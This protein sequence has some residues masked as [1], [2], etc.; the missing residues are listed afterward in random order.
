MATRG[1]ARI[2]TVPCPHPKVAPT[3]QA[4]A[5]TSPASAL[6]ERDLELAEIG[7]G[8]LGAVRRDGR[9]LLVQG[10]AGIGK[11]VLLRAARE[12]AAAQG[13][14][15][16]GATG[17]E[18]DRDFPFGIVHQLL[19]GVVAEAG[20][21]RRAALFAGAA[22]HAE[23]VFGGTDPA[24]SGDPGHVVLHAL[25]WLCA[26]LADEAPVALV[27]DDLHWADRASLRF[28]EFL[29]RRLEG[30][31]LLVVAA[32]RVDEPGADHEL[33]RALGRGPAARVLEPGPLSGEAT[34]R[35]L[36]DA[37]GADPEPAFAGASQDATGGNPLL[38]RT[39]ARLAAERGLRGRGDEAGAVAE[40]GARGMAD[41]VRGRLDGLGEDAILAARALAL[42]GERAVLE[43]VAALAAR[44]PEEAAAA[45]DT[46]ARA[47]IVDPDGRDFVHPL[48]RQ[49]VAADVPP[50][51]R[52][53]LHD[54]A[55]RRLAERRARVDEI[56]VHLLATDPSGD[57]WVVETLREAAA[58]ARGAGEAHA[59]IALLRRA[60]AEPPPAHDRAVVLAELGDAEAAGGQ[61]ESVD[62][63]QQALDAGL[64]GDAAARAA[65][66][67][68]QQ[69][70]G[71]DPTAAVAG[72]EQAL[73]LVREPRLRRRIQAQ[74][75]DVTMY[76]AGLAGRRPELL[77]VMRAEDP[78]SPALVGHDLIELGYRAGP[79]EL[80][81]RM[82]ERALDDRFFLDAVGVESGGYHLLCMA[83]RQSELGDLMGR[84]V[85]AGELEAR[86]LGS[87][88]AQFY[89]EHARA[90]HH[91][92]FGSLI[93]G[94]AHARE[95]LAIS[96]EAG[97]TLRE[98]SFVA[99]LGE[100]LIERDMLD[101]AAVRLA[102]RPF[103]PALERI[104]IAPDFLAIRGAVR[105]LRGRGEE[106][107]RDMRTAVRLLDERGWRSPLKARAALWL[108]ELLGDRGDR[109]EALELLAREEATTRRAGTDGTL[110][111]VLRLRG[112]Y[113]AGDEGLELLR[114]AV[115]RV[116]GTQLQLEQ[117]WAQF[118]LGAALRRARQRSEAREP[119]RAALDLA[120]R[121]GAAR[122]GGLAREEL[123][124]T[125]ARVT[126]DTRSGPE[127]LTP[128]ER[129]VAELAM[130][131]MSNKEIAE[132]LWVSRKTV[133]VHLGHAYAKLGIRS[134]AQLAGALDGTE[135]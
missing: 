98:L 129:R 133:E 125:G 26:N 47:G 106:A 67:R 124:A 33:L 38:L 11:T 117:A 44:T 84:A 107:E 15:V 90:H 14:R 92:L 75:L 82:G 40:I 108:A 53:T 57:S 89:M 13:A 119:L 46:L 86:R 73:T 114:E 104:I 100:I 35:L 63:L 3:L 99:L 61:P 24:A 56:A 81:R 76:D 80:V 79:R 6:L 5:T 69:L 115:R 41:V 23:P 97:L 77:E 31:P 111:T 22:A 9:L 101:E 8:A 131:G 4:M 121:I 105:R 123:L 127:A 112:R 110:G 116:S 43:D 120:D 27:V 12:E 45:I 39:L 74:L 135:A 66:V 49:A 29:G 19:D 58:G 54:R 25:Y 94:E 85:E 32:T 130:N 65:L 70:L 87:R 64:E 28:L 118:D 102:D 95:G 20:A 30:L 2:G 109:D 42:L 17:S 51:M 96:E 122:V 50:G 132:T 62:R 37:L 128:S 21:E 88:A 7:A 83:L 91:L 68:A 93:A 48:V 1:C 126:R 10:P 36:A 59:A 34:G 55:A 113:T 134:R 103:P 18:L 60:L 52:V 71:H 16:L 78:D 72:F